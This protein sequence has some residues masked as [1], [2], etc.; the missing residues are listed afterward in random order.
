MRAD[1]FWDAGKNQG[2]EFALAQSY[3]RGANLMEVQAMTELPDEDEA[4]T[5]GPDGVFDDVGEDDEPFDE[6]DIIAW[7]EDTEV[8]DVRSATD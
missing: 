4:G 7:E 5:I 3:S 2:L 8:Y 6:D 1:E